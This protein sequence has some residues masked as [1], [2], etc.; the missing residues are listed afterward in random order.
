MLRDTT[1]L[2]HLDGKTSRCRPGFHA[3]LW[4]S[5]LGPPCWWCTDLSSFTRCSLIKTPVPFRHIHWGRAGRAIGILPISIGFILYYIIYLLY[6]AC[7]P[8]ALPCLSNCF[9]VHLSDFFGWKGGPVPDTNT[10]VKSQKSKKKISNP[11]IYVFLC[12]FVCF[13]DFCT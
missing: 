7:H 2:E 1:A 12:V 13:C 3:M 11:C 4:W 8:I 10:W 6:C 9:R 5:R